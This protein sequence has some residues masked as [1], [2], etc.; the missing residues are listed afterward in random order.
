MRGRFAREQIVFRSC[1][2][3]RRSNPDRLGL[4]IG[5]PTPRFSCANW[6]CPNSRQTAGKARAQTRTRL[7]G[8]AVVTVGRARGLYPSPSLPAAVDIRVTS[9]SS[10]FALYQTRLVCVRRQLDLSRSS[11]K[12]RPHARAIDCY[13]P[14]GDLRWVFSVLSSNMGVC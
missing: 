2:N 5:L 1:S 8:S 4:P 6:P 11:G 13:F 7:R 12:L 3:H 14:E 10:K 9:E